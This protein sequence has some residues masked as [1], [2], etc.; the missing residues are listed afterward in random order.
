[1]LT[2][3]SHSSYSVPPSPVLSVQSVNASAEITTQNVIFEWLFENNTDY[4]LSVAPI[5]PWCSEPC[6][7]RTDQA[8]QT[9]PLQVGIQYNI[10]ARAEKC[11]GTLNS[12]N[13]E[14]IGFILQGTCS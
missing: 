6:L 5:P 4:V 10:T 9:I 8:T 13:S 11:N 7:Y 3:F 14:L 2:S 12:N 1:M